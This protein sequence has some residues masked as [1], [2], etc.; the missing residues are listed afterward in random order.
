[1]AQCRYK[2][3]FSRVEHAE[4]LSVQPATIGNFSNNVYLD[5]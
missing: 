3:T 1:M 4:I 2:Y 5:K